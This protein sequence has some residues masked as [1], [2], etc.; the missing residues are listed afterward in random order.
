[1]GPAA[2]VQAQIDTRDEFD[3]LWAL[4]LPI[5]HNVLDRPC[6]NPGRTAIATAVF[7]FITLIFLAGAAVRVF[8]TFGI[9]HGTQVW[10]FRVARSCC[11]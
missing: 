7:T 4:N 2:F 5:V 6:D 8:V 10:I 3:D 1:V 11:P 9:D